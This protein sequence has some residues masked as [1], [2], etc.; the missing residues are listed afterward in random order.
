[1]H[2]IPKTTQQ[3]NLEALDFAFADYDSIDVFKR[4]AKTEIDMIGPAKLV[5]AAQMMAANEVDRAELPWYLAAFRGWIKKFVLGA[6]TNIVSD[7]I[8]W[9]RR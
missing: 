9:V 5:T 8:T 4:F 3:S 1:M 7:S 2:Y 6:V